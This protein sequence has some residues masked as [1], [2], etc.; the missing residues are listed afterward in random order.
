VITRNI[1]DF[2]TRDWRAARAA[3]DDYWARRIAGLGACEGFRI[4]DQLRQ[5]AR[6]QVPE[7][8]SPADREQDLACHIT[9]ATRLRHVRRTRGR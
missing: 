4:A 8:P 5:Q 7:W 2:V 3:K 6:R 9:L 1:R